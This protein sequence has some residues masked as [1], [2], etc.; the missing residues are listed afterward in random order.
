[1]GITLALEP[2]ALSNQIRT[3]CVTVLQLA[4]QRCTGGFGEIPRGLGMG[5]LGGRGL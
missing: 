1:L 5:N 3:Q 4:V 2:I